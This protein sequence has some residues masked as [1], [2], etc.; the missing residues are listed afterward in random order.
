MTSGPFPPREKTRGTGAL[1]LRDLQIAKR[2]RQE[3]KGQPFVGAARREGERG[4]Y[5]A[6][7]ASGGVAAGGVAAAAG[8]GAGFAAAGFAVSRPR[9]SPSARFSSRVKNSRKL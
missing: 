2:V 3:K 7:G 5:A 9:R 1:Q 8:D 6:F 4:G